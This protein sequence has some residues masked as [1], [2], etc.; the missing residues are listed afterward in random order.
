MP[1][2][3]LLLG[4]HVTLIDLPL[5]IGA[6]TPTPRT[7][8]QPTYTPRRKE[9]DGQSTLLGFVG[10]PWTLA[11]YA[12]EG[13]ADRDCKQTKVRAR[14]SVQE[15]GCRSACALRTLIALALAWTPAAALCP[16]YCCAP[17]DYSPC[18]A[19][20]AAPSASSP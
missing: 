13:K 7:Q 9:V 18:S 19:A 15:G 6:H 20:E 1:P 11:A 2:F 4:V 10:T 5:P 12:M 16:D 14:A 17:H 8:P 3:P